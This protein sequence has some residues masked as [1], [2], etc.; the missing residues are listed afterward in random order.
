MTTA[1]SSPSTEPATREKILDAAGQM[2]ADQ[3]AECLSMRK[4]AERIEYSPT[5]IYLYFKDKD[6]LVQSVCDRVCDQLLEKFQAAG[7]AAMAPLSALREGL[8]I[9]IDH[10]LAH[11][12]EYEVT[13]MTR[14]QCPQGFTVEEMSA[15]AGGRAFAHLRRGVERC[16]LTGVFP[17]TDVETASQV[18][19]AGAHGITS[20][21]ITQEGFP[22]V[23][24]DRVID[25]MID[26]LTAG[27][28]VQL[29]EPPR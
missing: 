23:D 12:R 19:W 18:L 17:S 26:R 24:R 25:T 7:F 14:R 5:T 9:Y 27:F 6:E 20:L 22:W 28:L 8:R 11:P 15:T 2:L 16:V 29:A 13:F 1:A 21:L 10:G 4:V 3:G